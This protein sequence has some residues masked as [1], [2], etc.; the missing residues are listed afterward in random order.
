MWQKKVCLASFLSYFTFQLSLT[1]FLLL[2]SLHS[3]TP[4]L[5]CVSLL[6]MASYFS[7]SQWQELELQAL[8]FR[9]MLAGTS[10]PPELLQPIKKSLLHSPSFFLHHPLQHYQPTCKL[11]L[12]FSLH[13]LFLTL[14]HTIFHMM[15][16]KNDFIFRVLRLFIEY[17]KYFSSLFSHD[18]FCYFDERDKKTAKFTFLR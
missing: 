18:S 15:F 16:S 9:Y 14:L 13:V 8:I 10:V 5:V 11:L 12:C 3:L 4:F 7:L 2:D 6:G 1:F 17:P